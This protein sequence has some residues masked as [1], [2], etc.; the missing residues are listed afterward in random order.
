MTNHKTAPPRG[1]C[2]QRK[3]IILAGGTGSRLWPLTQSVSK[4]LLPV[5]DKPMIYYPLTQLLQAGIREIAVI[6]TPRDRAQYQVLLGDGR[7]WGVA[8]TYLVQPRPGGVAQAFVLAEDFLAGS[9]CLLA[10]GDNIHLVAPGS[11]AP[12]ARLAASQSCGIVGVPVSDTSAYGVARLSAHGAVRALVEKPRAGGPGLAVTGLYALD[13]RAPTMARSLRP[14]KRG[15]L[16]I[17]DLLNLYVVE[18]A[19]DLVQMPADA[20][21]FDAGTHDSLMA[22]AD[23]VR[24]LQ[25][26]QGRLVGSPDLA[27][28]ENGWID[29]A[30]LAAR[31]KGCGASGYGR[32]LLRHL[33]TM[34][35]VAGPRTDIPVPN[36]A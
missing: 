23:C 8:I 27:A 26:K 20:Q 14:S 36:A 33:A 3:G 13:H 28:L 10:L 16:E 15:E 2:P 9:S 22:A 21:W 34:D 24:S 19:V 31:V 35:I 5:Y 4:Q 1:T 29:A 30:E 11:T 25:D 32:A 6:T 12:A 17:V 7:Q 18:W